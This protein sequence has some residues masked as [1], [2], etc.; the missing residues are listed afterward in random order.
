MGEREKAKLDDQAKDAHAGPDLA[1]KPPGKD[2]ADQD[3]RLGGLAK[4]SE[5]TRPGGAEPPAS[6]S[7]KIDDS[8]QNVIQSFHWLNDAAQDKV[9]QL[10]SDIKKSDKS[11]WIEQVAEAMLNVALAGGAAAGAKVIADNFVDKSIIDHEFV[12]GL[13]KEG[14]SNGVKAGKEKLKYGNDGNVADSFID[15]QKEGVRGMHMSNQSHF[16]HVGRHQI[17]TPEQAAALEVACSFQNVKV[18]AVAQQNAT[19]DAWV[20][21]LAQG[22]YGSVGKRGHDGALAESSTTNMMPQERRDWANK[23]APDSVPDHAPEVTDAM[24]GNAPGVLFLGTR[25]PNISNNK[26]DGT[27]E[28]GEAILNGV[29]G[30]LR[31]HY[32]GAV[33]SLRIPRQIIGNSEGRFPLFTINLDENGATGSIGHKESAWLRARA[34]VGRPENNDKDDFDKKTE[35][36]N[37]L[38]EELRVAKVPRGTL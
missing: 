4:T 15:S 25:L 24:L 20:S 13:F 33:A 2:I 35:G 23:G 30:E 9:D 5:G 32:T 38:L 21:Y 22:K 16:I 8:L 31:S 3:D 28:V 37:L 19:R 10:R 11:P 17:K 27:P 7:R 29:N 36:L 6:A 34:T 12:K 26:M 18:A 1:P 14:I